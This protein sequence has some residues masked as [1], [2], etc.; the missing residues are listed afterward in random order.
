MRD[1]RKIFQVIPLI[2]QFGINMIVP[3]LMCTL[4]GV[5]LGKKLDMPFITV[6]LFV[7]GALAG[8]TNI[9]KMAKNIYRQGGK[10]RK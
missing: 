7:M 5:W 10:K 6:P 9:Y 8:F 2:L 3:I 4:F 1:N